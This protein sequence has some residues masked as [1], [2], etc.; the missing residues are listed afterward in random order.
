MEQL[1]GFRQTIPIEK[2]GEFL[3]TQP[4]ENRAAGQGV[5]DG[6]AE[7]AQCSV[8]GMVA[9][10]IVDR[11]EMIDVEHDECAAISGPARPGFI[12]G[13]SCKRAGQTVMVCQMPL[14]SVARS[15]LTTSVIR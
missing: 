10:G 15:S 5:V 2:K 8:A 3:A 9:I 12:E 11:L 14:R 6:G 1:L 13:G 4:A 7:G